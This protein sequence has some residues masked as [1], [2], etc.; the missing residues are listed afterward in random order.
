MK[1][2]IAPHTGFC[3]GVRKAVLRIVDEINSSEDE[4]LVYGPLIHNPQTIRILDKRGVKTIYDLDNINNKTVAIRTHGIPIESLRKIK[5]QAGRYIN[6]TC[7]RVAR[8]QGIVK[9]YSDDG[10][11]TIII[12]DPDHAEVES[13]K[14]YASSGVTV[15]PSPK[16]IDYIQKA[17]K[18]I[19][20]A[21]TTL[22]KAVYS[23][24]T[25]L[26]DKYHSNVIFCNTI[27]DSTH[28]RQ[29]DVTTAIDNGI[30]ALVVVGG[31]NSANTNRLASIGRDNN[32][33][34]F[35]V[36]TEEELVEDDFRDVT[37]VLVTAGASTPGWVINNVLEKLFDINYKN[38]RKIINIIKSFFEFTI[39]T[40]IISSVASAFMTMYFEW[41]LG[42]WSG[43]KLPAIS[44]MYVFSMYSVNNYFAKSSLKE[45]NPFKYKLHKKN[46]VLIIIITLFFLLLSQYL[47]FNFSIKLVIVYNIL[48]ITG[49]LYTT[50][51]VQKFVQHLPRNVQ[52]IYKMKSMIATSGWILICSLP[53]L[54]IP[55]NIVSS[56][57]I[58]ILPVFTFAAYMIIARNLLH[59]IIGYHGDLIIGSNTLPISIG[60]NGSRTFHVILST[61]SALAIILYSII[62]SEKIILLF[63]INIL[64]NNLIFNKISRLKYF[65][66][67]EYEILVD[68]NFLLFIIITGALIL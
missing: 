30:D 5:K 47:I 23:E 53:V 28:S 46:S 52:I 19:V 26:I 24:I 13:I 11:Y 62:A 1:I 66:T 33:K 22:N 63:M 67:L 31:K 6:L 60:I 51:I 27:C 56:N 68:M 36:E 49:I 57:L 64:Y 29:D 12:G 61:G 9:K 59:D 40:N 65:V 37:H 17:D 39:R 55:M 2:D 15:V 44:A 58:I 32:I 3:M 35:H 50:P 8:V 7:P 38:K 10:Y 21:Q 45:S 4:I 54:M 20:V 18:Y 16:Y 25:T 41:A 34:T 43:L 14:S 48:L 42:V